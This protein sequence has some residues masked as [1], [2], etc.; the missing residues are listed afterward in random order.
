VDSAPAPEPVFAVAAVPD[1]DEVPEAATGLSTA[2]ADDGKPAWTPSVVKQVPEA[3]R[4][5][6]P[7]RSVPSKSLI[8]AIA[9]IACLAA[10]LWA[11]F[12]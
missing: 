12:S 2:T 3:D 10:A 4:G 11:L 7:R 6:N 1:A 8:A 9:I 5:P